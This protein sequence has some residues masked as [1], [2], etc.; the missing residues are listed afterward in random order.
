MTTKVRPVTPADLPAITDI[1]AHAV[2]HGT[3]SY[4]Y[5]PPDLAEMTRR[6]DALVSANYPYIVA[7]NDAGT[8]LGYAYAG[9]FRTR[10]AYRFIVEDSIYIAPT[11]QGHGVGHQLL[12]AL[13]QQCEA[14][15]YRQIIAVIGDGE[16]NQASVKLHTALGFTPSGRITGSGYKHNHWCDTILMQRELNGGTRTDP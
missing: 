16:V 5:D 9:A 4:E 3:A 2:I 7:T 13:I 12:S 1:Y 11:A 14:S 15:G 10:P 6:H 8:I